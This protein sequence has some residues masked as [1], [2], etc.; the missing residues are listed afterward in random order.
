MY[1]GNIH[2]P[3]HAKL[4]YENATAPVFSLISNGGFSWNLN[5]GVQASFFQVKSSLKSSQRE[6]FVSSQVT[7]KSSQARISVKS[8]SQVI[9]SSG[10]NTLTPQEP[11]WPPPCSPRD[12]PRRAGRP[13][14]SHRLPHTHPWQGGIRLSLLT[15]TL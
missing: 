12:S 2:A 7:I 9:K 8:S 10:L 15:W 5:I 13:P 11:A 1:K 4:I 3:K 6:K 14:A